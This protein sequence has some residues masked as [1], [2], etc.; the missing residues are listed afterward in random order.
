MKYAKFLGLGLVLVALGVSGCSPQAGTPKDDKKATV[1][2]DGD[3]DDA[4]HAHGNGPNG[5]VTFD[6]GKVHVE[7]TVNHDKKEIYIHFLKEVKGKKEKDWGLLEVAVKELTLTTKE[8][9]VKEG[10]HKGKVVPLMTIKLLPK[11]AKDGKASVFVGTDP[12]L[13]NVAD[14][15]GTVLGVV[16][17][18]PSQGEFKE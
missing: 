16:D 4:D 18:K 10:K 9:K 15:E 14:F 13:G 11:D 1:R 2:H 7:L 6:L 8:T 17:G 3:N 5:G 12:G